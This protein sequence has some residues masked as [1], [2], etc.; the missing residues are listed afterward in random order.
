MDICGMFGIMSRK[1]REKKVQS[2]VGARKG[3]KLDGC[4][5]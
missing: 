3:E 5:R 1:V 4:G 2:A